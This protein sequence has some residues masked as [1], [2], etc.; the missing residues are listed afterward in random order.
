MSTESTF[1]RVLRGYDPDEVDAL[2]QKLRRELLTAK[3]LHDDLQSQISQLQQQVQDIQELEGQK[4]AP[5]ATGLS[6]Q[7]A[8]QLKKAD[9]MATAIITRAEADALLI[10]SAADKNSRTIIEAAQDGYDKAVEAA[11][12]DANR[13]V[14][15]AQAEAEQI[16]LSAQTKAE[17]MLSDAREESTLLRGEAATYIANQK[18][19]ALNQI[20]K[21]QAEN[22]RSLD[23]MRLILATSAGPEKISEHILEILHSHAESSAERTHKAAELESRHREAVLHTDAY[24]ANAQV[25]LATAKTKLREIQAQSETLL[26]EAKAEADAIRMAAEKDSTKII[27]KA[28]KLSRAKVADSEKYVA[29][30]LKS[31]YE[32]IEVLELEREK[33]SAFFDA[34]QLELEKTLTSTTTA[35]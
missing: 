30:V 10:R 19:E 27:R 15:Q 17:E 35:A 1:S 26:T 34:L 21:D 13:I 20:H 5:T 25:Q 31:I 14:S 24:L 28:E 16:I 12:E 6:A 7:V 3:Q 9:Q 4:S 2:I 22:Q 23:D 11:R 29:A 32:Q 33:I 8:K 18:A